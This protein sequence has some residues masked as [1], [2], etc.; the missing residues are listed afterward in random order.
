MY[1]KSDRIILPGR[2]AHKQ[3]FVVLVQAPEARRA[4]LRKG[5]V[6]V[7]DQ[8]PLDSVFTEAES[9]LLGKKWHW[10]VKRKF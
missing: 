6:Y 4:L 2:A 1:G 10:V 3:S 5:T 8:I 7:N 9:T